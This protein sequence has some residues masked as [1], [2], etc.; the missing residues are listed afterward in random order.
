[1]FFDSKMRRLFTAGTILISVGYALVCELVLHRKETRVTYETVALVIVLAAISP[2]VYVFLHPFHFRS[3]GKQLAHVG[4][5]KRWLVAFLVA[6]PILAFGPLLELSQ[7]Q[8]AVVNARLFWATLSVGGV[9]AYSPAPGRIIKQ[10]N[11]VQSIVEFTQKHKVDA[12]PTLTRRLQSQIEQNVTE[13]KFPQSAKLSAWEAIIS[14][15]TYN[16]FEQLPGQNV[17]IGGGETTIDPKSIQ[18]GSD[19]SQVLHIIGNDSTLLFGPLGSF[20]VGTRPIVFSGINFIG[21]SNESSPLGIE[22]TTTNTLVQNAK[23]QNVV[24]PIDL[25]IWVNVEF[26]NSTVVYHGKAVFLK[27]VRFKNCQFQF[28]PHADTSELQLRIANANGGPVTY[29]NPGNAESK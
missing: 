18:L 13:K 8:T 25:V 27:N 10:L 22:G 5:P 14:L 6:V 21:S 1:M 12:D 29:V 2:L 9:Y 7:I 19:P 17:S 20:G 4:V 15:A 23:L 28:D 26:E 16:N 11:N 3:E 24:Q